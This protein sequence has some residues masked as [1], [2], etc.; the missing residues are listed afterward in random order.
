MLSASRCQRPPQRRWGFVALL[1]LWAS[2]LV[3]PASL[4]GEIRAA[5]PEQLG[6]SAERLERVTARMN[7]AA[8]QG[9]MIGGVGVIARDGKVVYEQTYGQADREAARPMT[10]DAIFR[11]YSMTKPITGVAVMIL[12]EEGRFFL[13]D[14]I[15]KY[16]PQLA[17][18]KVARATADASSVLDDTAS[19]D[20]ESADSTS[21]SGTRE[22]LRQPT[23]RD[24]LKHTAGFTYGVFGAT[25][26]DEL[27]RQAGLLAAYQSMDDFIS[28]LGK[29]PLQYDPGTRWHYSVSV[30]VQGA[31]VEAVSGMGFGEFLQ[32]RIFEPLDMK[33]TSFVAPADKWGRVAQLYSPKGAPADFSAFLVEN[34]SE[35][36]AVASDS[37]NEGYRLGATFESGGGGLLSTARDYLR[38]CQMMLNG[39]ELNGVRLLSPASVALMTTNH[40][41]D[42]SMGYG[43]AGTGFG[44]GFAVAL[45]QGLIGELGSPGEYS[46]GGAAGTRFWIDPVERL[47]GL[48][49]VQSIPHR[50]RLGDEFKLLTYQA[51]VD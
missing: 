34:L 35:E 36:L 22:P 10:T 39:G 9:E 7:E 37:L 3:V 11:I 28:A 24:L 16:L 43:G 33:D 41:G 42:L 27:Y 46:W 40:L 38:F 47:I 26:V 30:D 31:L 25:E 2:V 45:D 5:R 50:T 8:A 44:L 20:E 21:I 32:Q 4:G 1:A 23:I 14:P 12:Y 48:F 17:D 18:L 51:L 15:A 6:F 29:I 49:M 13:N 19:S